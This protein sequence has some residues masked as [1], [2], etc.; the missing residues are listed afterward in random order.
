MSII[1]YLTFIYLIYLVTYYFIYLDN[2]TYDYL[3]TTILNFIFLITLPLYYNYFKDNIYSLIFGIALVIS[4]FSLNLQIKK[5][6]HTNKIPF[7]IY[8]LSTSLILG[9]IICT[10]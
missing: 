10:F 3:F 2:M 7:I 8:F 4:S 9:L 6:F 5:I 1:F